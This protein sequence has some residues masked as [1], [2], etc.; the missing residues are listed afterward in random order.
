MIIV[1]CCVTFLEL[2]HL[3]QHSG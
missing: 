1:S 2:E 3:S